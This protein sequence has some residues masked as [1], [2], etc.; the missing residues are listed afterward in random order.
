MRHEIVEGSGKENAVALRAVVLLDNQS[1]GTPTER[2]LHA[3]KVLRQVP[4]WR[5]EGKVAWEKPLAQCHQARKSALLRKVVHPR[6]SRDYLACL[7]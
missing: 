2:L 5:V 6:N 1:T 3:C 7:Q 4:G